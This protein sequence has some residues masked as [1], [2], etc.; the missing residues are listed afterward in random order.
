VE[1]IEKKVPMS[2]EGQF[3]KQLQE[4]REQHRLDFQEQKI[5]HE[6]E[7]VDLKQNLLRN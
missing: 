5:T 3:D 6:L 7:L 1:I 4:L 2:Q